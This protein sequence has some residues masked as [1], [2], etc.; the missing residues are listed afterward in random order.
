MKIIPCVYL[1]TNKYNTVLYAGV[2]NNLL[3]RI[4]EHKSKQFDGFSKKYN[5][6]KL[7]YYEFFDVMSEAIE[8]EKIIKGGSR[9]RKIDMIDK[10]NP[11]WKDL[12]DTL[13]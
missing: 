10:F 7:V 2:T 1:I 11:G 13:I 5:L 12:Y 4:Q 9:R 3:R 6:N 8:K